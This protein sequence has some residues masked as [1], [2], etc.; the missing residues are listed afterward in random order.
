M[1]DF[2]AAFGAFV[3]PMQEE[4]LRRR[5]LGMA[6]SYIPMQPMQ[7]PMGDPM[8]ATPMA[9][10]NMLERGPAVAPMYRPQVGF[11]GNRLEQ[12]QEQPTGAT[13]APMDLAAVASQPD[14]ARLQQAM[15]MGDRPAV[16][17]GFDPDRMEMLQDLFIGWAS[18]QNVSDSLA[19]GA[20]MMREGKKARGEKK[21]SEEQKNQTKAFLTSRGLDPAQAELVASS[22]A[23]LN[24]YL[25]ST[26]LPSQPNLTDDQEE[27]RQAVQ[28]GY[29]GSLVDFIKEVRG[30]GASQ[31][32]IADQAAERQKIAT[33]MG[34]KPDS[35]QFKSFVLTGRLPREDQ[36]TL[37]AIDKQAIQESDDAVMQAQGT[38]SLLDRALEIND[39]AYQGPFAGTRATVGSLLGVEGAQETLDLNNIVTEQAL[40]QL[41][42][43]FGGAPTEGERSILLDIAG[44]AN[45]PADV[46]KKIFERAKQAVQRRLQYHSDRAAELRGG[47]YY[48]PNGA[49]PAAP[50]QPAAPSSGY[51]ILGVE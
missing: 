32:T 41:K 35:D 19:K 34:L 49:A 3:P 10:G 22:P 40:S 12:P 23:V 15:P 29:K 2:N 46:R 45:Q 39:K 36:Q 33:E 48:Q 8:Q 42:A 51:K 7:G 4:L 20:L 24:E 16:Q 14:P 26:M 47:T 43:I 1:P 21:Q 11:S 5:M 13:G 9:P 44:S 18:G 30:A 38:M 37:T 50:M 25:K 31:I 27:Y 6:Q 17:R 28:Q